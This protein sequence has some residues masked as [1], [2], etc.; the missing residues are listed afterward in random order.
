MEG[1]LVE[2]LGRTLSLK[3][4]A[5]SQLALQSH[6][7]VARGCRSQRAWLHKEY[8]CTALE[9]GKVAPKELRVE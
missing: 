6:C 3:P 7:W 8:H 4:R 5:L 2:C 9:S 1:L